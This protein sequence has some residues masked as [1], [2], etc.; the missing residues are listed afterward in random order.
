MKTFIAVVLLSLTLLSSCSLIIPPASAPI[1][2]ST[3]TPWLTLTPSP[4]PTLTPTA[5]P[6]L[7]VSKQKIIALNAMTD[8]SSPA[9]TTGVWFVGDDGFIAHKFSEG[10]T[11]YTESPERRPLNDVD[12]I[13]PDDGW[14]VGAG[15]LIMHWNGTKWNV[16]KPST[17]EP[18]YFYNL[19]QVAFTDANDGWAAGD[20]NSEGGCQFLIYHWDGATWT[21][22]SLPEDWALLGCVHD[23][24]AL[25]SSDVWVVGTNRSQG[26]EVGVTV[27]WDGN[28]WKIVSELSSYNIYSVSALSPNNIWAITG[29]GVVLNWDGVEWKEEIQLDRA[30]TIFAQTPDD[31]FAV[32]TKIWYS[33]GDGWTDISLS[34]NLPADAEIKG[35]IAPYI[36]E[37][38]YP[39]VWMLD[40]S[41]I[42]YTFTH[43]RT[44]RR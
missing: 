24:A 18:Y 27:H 5:I 16:A 13:S 43:P 9:G 37:S 41:G 4:I 23:M 22:V 30:N 31:I 32:G 38:G 25:S 26:T 17:F 19:S 29:K 42:L 34:T 6:F 33:N 35:I 1:L 12:F 44:F 3:V 11:V 21:E 40:T 39:N 7:H 15:G 14:I 36:A 20:V 2:V 8:V 10:Y 28:D